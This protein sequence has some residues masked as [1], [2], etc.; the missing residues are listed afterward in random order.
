LHQLPQLSIAHLVEP[1]ESSPHP[2][3]VEL[4]GLKVAFSALTRHA[5]RLP[6]RQANLAEGE[7]TETQGR[8]RVEH[9]RRRDRSVPSQ[10]PSRELVDPSDD[11]DCNRDRRLALCLSAQFPNQPRHIVGGDAVEWSRVEPRAKMPLHDASVLHLR[12][13]SKVEYRPVEPWRESA[14]LGHP[15]AALLVVC[16]SA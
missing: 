1:D 5:P 3:I 6:R 9:Q 13:I 14:S 10:P 8:T 11:R 2:F 15:V 4:D 12:G 7:L 16:C